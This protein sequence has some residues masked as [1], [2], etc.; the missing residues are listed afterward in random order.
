MLVGAMGLQVRKP[1]EIPLANVTKVPFGIDAMDFGA[2]VF[3]I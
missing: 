1:F 3:P 2:M